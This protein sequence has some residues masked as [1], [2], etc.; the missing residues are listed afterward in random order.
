MCY[1]QLMIIVGLCLDNG[2]SIPSKIF[3]TK[4]MQFLGRISMSLYLTHEILIHYIRLIFYGIWNWEENDFRYPQ[5]SPS[6]TIPVHIII[7]LIFGTLMTFYFEEPIRKSMKQWR[8]K[9]KIKEVSKKEPGLQ[10]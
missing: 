3:K 6:W 5:S 8:Q 10:S 1:T 9:L 2:K 4:G 7:S